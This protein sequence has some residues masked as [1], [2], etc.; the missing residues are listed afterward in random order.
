MAL[1]GS[2]A[3]SLSQIQTEFGGSNPIS[4]SEYYRNGAYTTSNNTSV[5]TSGAIAMTTFYSGSAADYIPN[6]LAWSDISSTTDDQGGSNYVETATQTLAGINQ[7]IT[8]LVDTSSWSMTV[9]GA[10]ASGSGTLEAIVGGVSV[11]SMS[12]LNSSTGASSGTASRSMTFTVSSGSVVKFGLS[13]NVSDGI[14]YATGQTGATF[15]VKNNSS[16]NTVLDTFVGDCGA[17]TA[18]GA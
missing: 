1:Q 14:G 7:T 17:S 12:L 10:Q 15:S 11:A 13:V 2:G 8:L 9:A 4:L 16:G 3:I 6:A 5:P 18:G